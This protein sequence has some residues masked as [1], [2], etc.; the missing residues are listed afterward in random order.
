MEHER[1]VIPTCKVGV[2]TGAFSLVTETVEESG[3]R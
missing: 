3:K 1:T 2:K